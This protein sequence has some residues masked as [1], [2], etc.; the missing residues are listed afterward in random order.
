M[1]ITP[2]HNGARGSHPFQAALPSRRPSAVAVATAQRHV[3]ARGRRML[4]AWLALAIGALVTLPTVLPA[5]EPSARE[6]ELLA[7]ISGD[8]E[9]ADKALACKD[10]AIYGSAAS[11]DALG[12]LLTNERL[13]SW[14]RI[15]L[16]AI[17]GPE[18]DATLRRALPVVDGRTL[19]G[20][21]NTLGVRGDGAAVPLLLTRL[22]GESDDVAAAAAAALGRIGGAAAVAGLRAQLG[23]MNDARRDVA[24]EALVVAGEHLLAAGDSA[25]AADLATAVREADVPEQ[26]KAE[27]L[28]LAILARGNEGLPLLAEAFLE[29]S[30]RTFT[31]AV[32]TARELPRG[33]AGLGVDD[34]VAGGVEAM[35]AGKGPDSRAIVLLDVLAERGS[36]SALPLVLR[37]AGEA[38]AAVR[39]A[40]INA[41]GRIGD[42]TVVEVLLAAAADDDQAVA[43]AARAALAS[44]TGEAIDA[45]IVER[46]D[47]DNP[48]VLVAVVE[49]V[50]ARRIGAGDQ[51]VPLVTHAEEPV[52]IAA[53]RSLGSVGDIHVLNVIIARVR[54]SGSEA[55]S[56]AARLALLEAAVRMP[57]RETCAERISVALVDAAEA[58]EAD[59]TLLET[60]AEV[61]GTK[62][63]ATVQKAATSGSRTLEDAA[64]R[65]L[66]RWMT[67]DAGPVLLDLAK[68]EDGAFRG[69][70]LRGYLRIA[71]QFALPDAERAAMCRQALAA[72]TD[73]AERQLVVEI[74]PRHPSPQMLE[75][76]RDAEKMPGV[77]AEAKAAA[78]EIEQKLSA[79]AG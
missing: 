41:A 60:L 77:A 64:T 35:L 15:A 68:V 12:R 14:A 51:L 9:E 43:E 48:A 26:R 29:P 20:V 2:F 78:A 19:L 11:V 13:A 50:G 62:A 24:A 25:A 3:E 1:S 18:A 67:A 70:A 46:L 39:L 72:A 52:R 31:M 21:I 66:G 10:L 33:E 6:S 71:R 4:L 34:T 75:V 28:R 17:P 22:S 79:Q 27:A 73:D 58:V 65:L 61:G 57:D 69:R 49:A 8:G 40:A 53:L 38:P 30:R 5:A 45:V 47:A 42:M 7:V 74:L 76:A 56:E 59:V 23:S 54:E 37:L 63:L 44:L 16:E 36:V 32:A 55:E